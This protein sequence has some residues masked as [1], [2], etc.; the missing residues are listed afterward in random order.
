[1]SLNKT[2]MSI[3]VMTVFFSSMDAAN[4]FPHGC[5]VTGFAFAQNYL[6]V[7][8]NGEQSFYLIQNHRDSPVELQRFETSEAFMSPPL[9]IRLDPSMWAAFASDI[10][11]LHFQCWV[12]ENNSNV[13][14]DCRDVLDV[15]QYPRV[16]FALSNM[17][18]YWVSTNKT[19]SEVIN[20]AVGKGILLRW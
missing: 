6:V 17:G 7:N 1:M 9:T 3:I 18:N 5:E 10:E 19:Q 15:C 16:K 13:K 4:A 20:E 11:H 12:K 8:E 2:I 14:I